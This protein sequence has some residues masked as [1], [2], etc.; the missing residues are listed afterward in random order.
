MV[1]KR[2]ENE[3][4]NEDHEVA[5]DQNHEVAVD[6]SHEIANAS[7]NANVAEDREVVQNRAVDPDHV[8][9]NASANVAEDRA[10]VHV[11]VPN[12]AVVHAVVPNRVVAVSRVVFFVQRKANHVRSTN[13]KVE[14]HKS[15]PHVSR[16]VPCLQVVVAK[17]IKS[18]HQVTHDVGLRH[19]E[20]KKKSQKRKQ[21]EKPKKTLFFC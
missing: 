11:V 17:C 15:L 1:V 2:N 14:L 8:V 18:L 16:L 6:Q 4:A 13:E 5:A 3:D 20:S 9:A 21:K 19:K 12:R 10:V 7:A